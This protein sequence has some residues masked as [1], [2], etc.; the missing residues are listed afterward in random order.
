MAGLRSAEQRL[1]RAILQVS[2]KPQE[3]KQRLKSRALWQV[4]EY[5]CAGHVIDAQ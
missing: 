4:Q 2:L 5:I 3:R 1:A